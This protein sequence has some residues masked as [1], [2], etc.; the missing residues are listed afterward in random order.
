MLQPPL[1]DRGELAFEPTADDVDGNSAV[2]VAVNA[3][4]LFSRNR[5]VPDARQDS[6]NDLYRLCCS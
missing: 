3:G 5:W 6:S 2:A 1:S 4:N